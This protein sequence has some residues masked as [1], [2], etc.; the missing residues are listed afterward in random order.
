MKDPQ[1]GDRVVV[2]ATKTRSELRGKITRLTFME[3]TNP[4]RMAKGPEDG[5]PDVEIRPDVHNDAVAEL[6]RSQYKLFP[7]HY[8]DGLRFYAKELELES[9]LD[10]LAREA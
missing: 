6:R 7:R 3:G 4:K 8:V 2:K 10:R 1:L 9:L 5:D